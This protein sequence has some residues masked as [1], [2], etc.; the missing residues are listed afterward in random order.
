MKQRGATHRTLV[1]DSTEP[2][3]PTPTVNLREN[4]GYLLKKQFVTSYS[5]YCITAFCWVAIVLT[6]QGMSMNPNKVESIFFTTTHA[7]SIM[8]RSCTGT[9]QVKI[10]Q[11]L[12]MTV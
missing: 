11:I 1:I 9:L 2:S 7:A 5:L 6:I 10:S 12:P 4:L 3:A 8:F